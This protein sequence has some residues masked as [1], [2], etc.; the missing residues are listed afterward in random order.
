MITQE[1]QFYSLISLG[2]FK[3]VLGIDDRED[4][5]ARFCLVTATYTIEQ[6]CKRRLFRKKQF[7]QIE[8]IGDLLLPLREYPVSRVMAVYAMKN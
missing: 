1:N 8:Y 2:E 3:V 7:E 5:L 6:F 4:K